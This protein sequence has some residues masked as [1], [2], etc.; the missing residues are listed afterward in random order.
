MSTTISARMTAAAAGTRKRRK[1]KELYAA[2]AGKG[3]SSLRAKQAEE[4]PPVQGE[5]GKHRANL[6]HN[7]EG[8]RLFP[9]EAQK[10]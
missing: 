6:Y 2:Q 7:T 3:R 4:A 10:A 5:H 9:F 8:C 1:Y